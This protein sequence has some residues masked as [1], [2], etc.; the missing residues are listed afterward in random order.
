[1]YCIGVLLKEARLS[2][3]S[4]QKVDTFIHKLMAKEL[5]RG[6]LDVLTRCVVPIVAALGVGQD[7]R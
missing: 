2:L 5:S 1:M 6:S 7:H 4:P 3:T